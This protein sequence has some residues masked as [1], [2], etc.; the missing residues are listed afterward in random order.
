M[1]GLTIF[2][3][4]GQRETPQKLQKWLG[5][6][7]DDTTTDEEGSTAPGDDRQRRSSKRDILQDLINRS[8]R[9]AGGRSFSAPQQRAIEG[10]GPPQR[11]PTVRGPPA[12]PK[13][14][15]GN[16]ATP[17]APLRHS[18]PPG[19][20]GPIPVFGSGRRQ[21]Q[22]APNDVSDWLPGAIMLGRS[23]VTGHHDPGRICRPRTLGFEASPGV[24]VCPWQSPRGRPL[25]QGRGC[26]IT[27]RHH[28]PILA[29]ASWVA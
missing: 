13:P 22:L 25:G 8:L 18:S 1:P 16:P 9:L 10:C 27:S 17:Q 6:R 4:P 12:S 23:R 14:E 28:C 26:L 2:K 7:A 11:K 19:Q 20:S 21:P 5:G 29:T 3:R 15:T 24:L